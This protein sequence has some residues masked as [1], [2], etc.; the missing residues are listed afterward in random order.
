VA[1]TALAL[2]PAASA[3]EAWSPPAA[4]PDAVAAA[5][6]GAP[7]LLR[8]P[9]D[10]L[11]RA[12]TLF[13]AAEAVLDTARRHVAAHGGRLQMDGGADGFETLP[14]DSSASGR[15]AAQRFARELRPLVAAWS[16]AE[17]AIMV[18]SRLSLSFRVSR[19]GELRLTL[20]DARFPTWSPFSGETGLDRVRPQPALTPLRLAAADAALR[21]AAPDSA[22]KRRACQPWRLTAA[23]GAEPAR[24]VESVLGTDSAEA[25][26]AAFCHVGAAAAIGLGDPDLV[27][28]AIE[29]AAPGRS[30]FTA[31]G[32]ADEMRQ[33]FLSAAAMA[34]VH[35]LGRF[36]E[37]RL[38]LASRPAARAS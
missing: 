23:I 25:L 33:A 20:H 5:G 3:T 2:R 7:V 37:P 27:V 16:V 19:S 26:C 11:L 13:A 38:A 17:R 31:A 35:P 28:L 22:D 14:A 32:N 36:A 18:P 29:P 30:S 4:V 34:A 10:S 15:E 6:A 1:S 8:P 9:A 21:L 12:T 24:V